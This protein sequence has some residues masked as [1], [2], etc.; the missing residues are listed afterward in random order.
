[1]S[2]WANSQEYR[3]AVL[4]LNT[5]AAFSWQWLNVIYQ[6]VLQQ[7]ADCI[8]VS[9]I[10]QKQTL[11]WI[12]SDRFWH[13]ALGTLELELKAETQSFKYIIVQQL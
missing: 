4:R 6:L 12:S 10:G 11:D 2:H 8:T 7:T 9:D 1:M 3:N 5:I 13:I